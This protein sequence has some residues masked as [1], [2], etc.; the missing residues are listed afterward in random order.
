KRHR[1]R[2]KPISVIH[3]NYETTIED[4]P[5]TQPQETLRPSRLGVSKNPEP[6]SYLRLGLH[7]LKGLK[8]ATAQRIITERNN[9]PFESLP[10][11]LRRVQPNDKERRLLAASGALNP[12]PEVEHR[13][14]A[15]WQSE[16][17]LFDDLFSRSAGVPPVSQAKLSD[18]RREATPPNTDH[19]SLGTRHS[20]LGVMSPTERLATDLALTGSTTGPH[21]MA[22]WR[23]SLQLL[24]SPPGAKRRISPLLTAHCSLITPPYRA[25]DL[26]SLNHGV[27]ITI[28]GM[29]ICRQ[30]PS[31]AKGHCFISLE[32]ETGI[33]NLFVPRDTFHQYKLLITTEPFLLIEGRL[34]ISEGGQPT[35]Y[36]TALFPLPGIDSSHTAGSHDFH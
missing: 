23:R 5:K 8:K 21:P 32:D 31:T 30:R 22:L 35:V 3:S 7:R 11:F 26:P 33:A 24:P 9:Q 28:A 18:P 25:S 15:L 13:R 2:T 1:V 17:P 14:H 29:V 4:H 27:P 16:L 6:K 10:D 34:Q 12:L 36:T 20:P 19:C